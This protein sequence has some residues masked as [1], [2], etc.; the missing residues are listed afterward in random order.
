MIR[1]IFEP[2]CFLKLCLIFDLKCSSLINSNQKIICLQH[3]HWQ[4]AILCRLCKTVLHKCGHTNALRLSK[5]RKILYLL[6]S[7]KVMI[8]ER[9]TISHLN[10]LVDGSKILE[11]ICSS[12]RGC[13]TTSPLKS[14]F[15]TRKVAWQLL[16]ELHS[17]AWHIL[18]PTSRAKKWG[19]ICL[20]SSSGSDSNCL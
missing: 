6:I 19:I 14:V 20:R 7:S 2:L 13:H 1:F 8:V 18:T 4:K 9:Q 12:F 15:F 17:W 10:A 11:Q 3:I 5:R 16:I